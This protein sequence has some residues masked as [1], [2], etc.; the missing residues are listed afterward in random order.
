M[1]TVLSQ[2]TVECLKKRDVPI[3]GLTERFSPSR[4]EKA[5]AFMSNLNALRKQPGHC[6][7][8]GKK[9]AGSLRTCDKCNEYYK[10]RREAKLNA[11]KYIT[12]ETHSLSVI[13]KRL[14]SVENALA[15]IQTY[16]EKR[17]DAGYRAGC[18]AGKKGRQNI[19]DLWAAVFSGREH[20]KGC[21]PSI[22]ELRQY[23][24]EFSTFKEHED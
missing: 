10:R 11:A 5:R 8:C 16:A 21:V 15:R 12:V 18:T 2:G 9:H 6:S 13:L 14:E 22:E 3:A 24:H 17:Y 4:V 19:R 7:R 1:R 23:C 20:M